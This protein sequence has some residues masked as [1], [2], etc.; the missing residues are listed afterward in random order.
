GRPLDPRL[1]QRPPV[2]EPVEEVD[3]GGEAD[4]DGLARLRRQLARRLVEGEA[5]ALRRLHRRLD[6][7]EREDVGAGAL[8]VER[9]GL[10]ADGGLAEVEAPGEAEADGLVERDDARRGLLRGGGEGG[11]AA[12]EGEEAGAGDQPH[13]S[14]RWRWE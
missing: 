13:E 4:V 3:R 6:E 10:V 8:D 12:D 14:R 2:A 1:L 11:E 7:G 5:V 9:G